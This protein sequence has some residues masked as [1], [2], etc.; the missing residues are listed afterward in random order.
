MSYT[1]A[2]KLEYDRVY[3]A[4]NKEKRRIQES[5][6]RES[7]REKISNYNK[8]YWIDNPSKLLLITCK[9]RAKKLGWEF[10]LEES[11]I[12]IPDVCPILKFSLGRRG[13]TKDF[14]PSLDRIDNTKGYIKGNVQVISWRA[15]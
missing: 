2:E 14:S 15:N 3:R 6:R 1:H 8:Q 12:I 9:A 7:N 5:I 13:G 11:D 10:N 4:K